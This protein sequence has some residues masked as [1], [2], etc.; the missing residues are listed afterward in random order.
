[1]SVFSPEK[2]KQ[3]IRGRGG[4]T[5]GYLFETTLTFTGN[6]P[7][8]L[9]GPDA[10]KRQ[11]ALCRAT[12]IPAAVIEATELKYFT[13]A[14]KI[15]GARTYPP[16]TLTFLNTKDYD[17]Y[18]L[19]RRWQGLLNGFHG[20]ARM[21]EDGRAVGGI[22]VGPL[23]T[24]TVGYGN[25]TYEDLFATVQLQHFDVTGSRS[26]VSQILQNAGIAT[27]TFG[28]GHSGTVAG[29]IG[30]FFADTEHEAI[31]LYTLYNVFPTNIG[32]LT[33]GH[34]SE[35]YQTFDVE[36]QYL[37]MSFANEY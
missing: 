15:P 6:M 19:M 8:A 2:F 17:L 25:I 14:V 16:I 11:L 29:T 5:K 24:S 7:T 1:M 21:T 10:Q 27:G 4:L 35:E 23:S 26:L 18:K 13:R 31:G 28:P 3:A 36:F 9:F 30:A 34:D 12:T 20:N 32:G 37:D 22:S 33:F